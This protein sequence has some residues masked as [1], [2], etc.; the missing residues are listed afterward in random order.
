MKSF[1]KD[2][3]KSIQNEINKLK[4]YSL[5]KKITHYRYIHEYRAKNDVGA[6]VKCIDALR[7]DNKLKLILNFQDF[8]IGKFGVGLK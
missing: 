7:I 6:L 3:I 4:K 8:L 2:S 5:S 1:E